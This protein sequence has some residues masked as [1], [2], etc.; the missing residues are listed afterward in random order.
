MSLIPSAR[1][2]CARMLATRNFPTFCSTLSAESSRQAIRRAAALQSSRTSR[3]ALLAARDATRKQRVQ[4]RWIGTVA[5]YRTA[6]ALAVR[7]E[8]EEELE[9]EEEIP[10]EPPDPPEQTSTL[11]IGSPTPTVSTRNRKRRK[12]PRPHEKLSK[13]VNQ[14]PE[15]VARLRNGLTPKVMMDALRDTFLD[16]PF[17]A[18]LR[19]A[20]PVMEHLTAEDFDGL[21]QSLIKD[22]RLYPESLKYVV[23]EAAETILIRIRSQLR[24]LTPKASRIM[25]APTYRPGTRFRGGRITAFIHLCVIFRANDLAKTVFN[26]DLLPQLRD[27]TTVK[28]AKRLILLLV[29]SRSD[30]LC[31]ELF[32]SP[33]FPAKPAAFPA[34]LFTSRIMEGVMQAHLRLRQPHAV[35]R[36]FELHAD[37]NLVP[38]LNSYA[39]YTQ[40]LVELGELEAAK[41]V[42]RE[43]AAADWTD[44]F[45]QR[46]AI[47]RGQR[48]LGFDAELE[49]N[50]LADIENLN[51]QSATEFLHALILLRLDGGDS[52][53]A[54]RLLSRFDLGSTP[55]ETKHLRPDNT[56]LLL[57]FKVITR[58][59]EVEQLSVWWRFIS[60]S[61]GLATDAITA[62]LVEALCQ[63]NLADEAFNMV[64]DAVTG[65][66]ISTTW[67]MPPNSVKLGIL[68][69]NMLIRGMS[70]QHGIV[71]LKRVADLMRE[72]DIEADE[73][74]LEHI[75]N[76]VRETMQAQPSE[77]AKLLTDLLARAPDLRAT[78]GHL[79]V[80]M[81]EAVKLADSQTPVKTLEGSGSSDTLD[82]TAGLSP[83]GGFDE[84]IQDIIQSLRD[85]GVRSGPNSLANR[86]R[87]EAMT[88]GTING[89]PSARIVWNELVAR[90]YKP[91]RRHLLALMQGYAS[92]GSMDA[93]EDVLDL[94]R[95]TG[96]PIT[97][98]VLMILLNGWGKRGDVSR[99]EHAYESIR[100][101]GA[102]EHGQGLDITAVTAMIRAFYRNGKFQSAVELTMTDLPALNETVDDLAV[103]SASTAL[104]LLED[105]SA[106]LNL[107]RSNGGALNKIHRRIVRKLRARLKRKIESGFA[108]QENKR[109][110][111]MANE[112]LAKDDE[113]RPVAERRKVAKE[114]KQRFESERRQILELFGDA[115]NDRAENKDKEVLAIDGESRSRRETS[116]TASGKDHDVEE[117]QDGF[118]TQRSREVKEDSDSAITASD[119]AAGPMERESD[120]HE[121]LSRQRTELKLSLGGRANIDLNVSASDPLREQLPSPSS[122]L[123]VQAAGSETPPSPRPSRSKTKGK[124]NRERRNRAKWRSFG[125][126]GR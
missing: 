87:F 12:S 79:D 8:E 108:T 65:S 32:S 33:D 126:S 117:E 35:T 119:P 113:L 104:L 41:V 105:Y 15:A 14:P 58:H 72:S 71:G 75:I 70:V 34:E 109:T 74:T 20:Q 92:A 56:T 89:V 10:P 52:I 66:D 48:S 23:H 39:H 37:Y 17:G 118:P 30:R 43:T 24:S 111:E 94:A 29:S 114:K 88:G 68:T 97:R 62:L 90:G 40:A 116:M 124:L 99:A 50:A 51:K 36:F 112:T 67:K 76:C 84:A 9:E 82:A 91:T 11:P 46:L 4:Q 3:P 98:G 16:N 7:E 28:S 122:E 83:V 54:K 115:P 5:G 125:Y 6:S 77:L 61:S 2:G 73:K 57:A 22:S 27:G 102:R 100:R 1:N 59:P 106:A 25:E 69:L 42:Q 19:L 44:Q 31:V 18:F 45:R 85:R 95:Q 101:L 13:P 120:D 121:R 123:E 93:A 60:S 86:L 80:I 38:T 53:G 81:A 63:I 107:I 55:E 47:M 96:N 64:Q 110:L 49:K 103:S 26:Q 21:A 78:I